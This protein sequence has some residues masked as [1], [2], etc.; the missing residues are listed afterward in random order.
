[1]APSFNMPKTTIS[2]G[3][4]SVRPMTLRGL[5]SGQVLVLINGKRRHTHRPCAR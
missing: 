1:L 3:S 2:D 5:S 4:D